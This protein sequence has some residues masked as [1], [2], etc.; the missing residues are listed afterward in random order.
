MIYK[1]R[2]ILDT[3]EDVLRDIAIKDS[4][5]LEDLHNAIINA[6]GFDGS[7]GGS[8]FLC[9]D[10]WEQ[11]D[12]EIALFDMGDIPGE[13]KTMADFAIKDLLHEDQTKIL[14]IY[15][16]F[17]NWT[18]FV[19]LAS[20][21]SEEESTEKELPAL[22]FAHGV[23]PDQAPE[24]NFSFDVNQEDIYGEFD[25]DYD[26][27]DYGYFGDDEGGYDDYGYDDVY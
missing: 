15:D 4:D 11:L 9:E 5:N 16:P 13:Q 8:F 12:D 10:N 2:V 20:I 1:F 24:K 27:E 14:Y 23:I 25:D 7:E 22:L 17:V 21:E 26:D 18:F 3:D 6:F 19:E